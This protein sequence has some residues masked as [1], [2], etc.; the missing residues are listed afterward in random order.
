ME[1]AASN[2]AVMEVRNCILTV[3]LKSAARYERKS[4]ATGM[5]E[6]GM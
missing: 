4:E 3:V 1:V 5:E 6:G 2:S